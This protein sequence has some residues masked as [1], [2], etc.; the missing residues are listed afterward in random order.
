MAGHVQVLAQPGEENCF[1]EGKRKSGGL[2][3]LRVT[4]NSES[5]TFIG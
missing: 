5:M 3:F 4:L 2:H 1:I